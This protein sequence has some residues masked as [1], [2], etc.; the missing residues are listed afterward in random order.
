LERYHPDPEIAYS[1]AAL[2]RISR[3]QDGTMAA[4]NTANRKRMVLGNAME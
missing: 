1:G 3:K 2:D 4:R